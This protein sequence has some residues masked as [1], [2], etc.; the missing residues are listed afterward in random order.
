MMRTTAIRFQPRFQSR[1]FMHPRHYQ[2]FG[3]RM[4]S[5]C[6]VT[7]Q[8]FDFTRLPHP[9]TTSDGTEIKARIHKGKKFIITAVGLP[10]RDWATAA[11]ACGIRIQPREGQKS[12]HG[13]IKER[14]S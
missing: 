13:S 1:S 2:R 5:T 11:V 4:L 12:R 9:N 3:P 7:N 10:R 8:S 14:S 6:L